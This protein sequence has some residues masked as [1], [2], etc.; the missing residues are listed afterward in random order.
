[1]Y[2]SLSVKTA[3]KVSSFQKS[4]KGHDKAM[5]R[6]DCPKKGKGLHDFPKGFRVAIATEAPTTPEKC[7]GLLDFPKG[8]RVAIATEAPDTPRKGQRVTEQ[9]A[10]LLSSSCGKMLSGVYE[11]ADRKTFLPGFHTCP[12]L[13]YISRVRV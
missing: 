13:F 1:M 4:P 5:S 2:R 12:Y 11:R 7:K 3:S 9:S 8:F 10:P 6:H